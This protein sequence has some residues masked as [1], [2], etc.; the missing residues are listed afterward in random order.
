M[1]SIFFMLKDFMILKKRDSIIPNFLQFSP[2]IFFFITYIFLYVYSLYTKNISISIST[3]LESIPLLAAFLATIYAFYT[4]KESIKI[5]KK[6]EIFLSGIATTKVIHC[7]F[8]IV[9]LIIFNYMMAK[10]NGTLVAITLGLLYIPA[11]VIFPIIFFIAALV[12]IIIANVQASIIILLPIGYGI[13]MSLHGDSALMAATIIS[14]AL[15]GNHAWLYFNNITLDDTNFNL[16]KWLHQLE[17]SV[18]PIFIATTS[19]IFILSQYPCQSIS[20]NI[21]CHL[22]NS[23][24]FYDYVTII[25]YIFLLL[26]RFFAINFVISIVIASGIALIIE[27]ILHKIMFFDAIVTIFNGF[28]AEPI[29]QNLLLLHFFIAGLTKIMQYNGGFDWIVK[30]LEEKREQGSL[31]MNTTAIIMTILTNL[32]V[33][34]DTSFADYSAKTFTTADNISKNTIKLFSDITATICQTM[35]PYGSIMFLAI[36]INKSSYLTIIKYMIYPII[37]MMITLS[38]VLHDNVYL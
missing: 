35:I 11:T 30:K 6:I 27:I 18:I 8:A 3:A 5:D 33:I 28:Y 16:K 15:C 17:P 21:L 9:Y 7:Y 37:A 23:L 1:H 26:S 20:A 25:P 12:S 2:Y 14:G 10:I 32:F 24:Q 4:F 38:I 22:Q 29:V 36:Y 13:A 19:T 34:I 31:N